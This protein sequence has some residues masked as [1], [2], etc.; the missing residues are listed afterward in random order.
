MGK[1]ATK[2][3]ELAA[4]ENIRKIVESLGENSY[5]GTAFEGCFDVA[6]ENIRNDFFCSMKQ[7]AESAERREEALSVK[8]EKLAQELRACK[9]E[10]ERLAK[11]ILPNE[12]LER[13]ASVISVRRAAVLCDKK[14]A[15]EQVLD[16]LDSPESDAYMSGKKAYKEAVYL[17]DMLKNLNEKLIQ[18]VKGKVEKV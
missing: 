14:K 4:L 15:A 9:Q 8:S 13:L 6:E 18:C 16:N 12:D 5:V 7:R 10:N 1:V 3:Q 2:E 11:C 17:E